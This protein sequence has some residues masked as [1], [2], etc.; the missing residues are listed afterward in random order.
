MLALAFSPA[1][2]QPREV[3]VGFYDN[4]PKVL[5]DADGRPAGIF[6]DLIERVAEAEDW[7]LA[8]E[9]CEWADCLERTVGGE[10]DLMPDVAISDARKE[11][12][13]FHAQPVLHSWS[14]VYRRPDVPISS[15]LDLKGRR[16]ALL[17]GSIQQA[18]LDA[19]LGDFG[20]SYE[21]VLV[22]D[23]RSAFAL[24]AQGE[25]DAAVVN[26]LFGARYHQEFDLT[27][28][29]MV[30]EPSRLFFATAKGENP[31]LLAVID[32]HLSAWQANGDSVFFDVLERWMGE[33]PRFHVPDW[34]WWM[35][36]M[37]LVLLLAALGVSTWLRRQVA[38]RTRRL[39]EASGALETAYQVIDASPVVLFRW[40]LAPGWPVEYVSGNVRRWGYEAE[41]F[42][43]GDL[44]FADVVHPDDLARVSADVERH[45]AGDTDAFRQEYRIV[46]PDGTPR[47]VEDLTRVTRDSQGRVER[48]EGVVTDVTERR[49]SE[50]RQR[51]AAAVIENTLEGVMITDRDERIIMVNRAFESLT[52]YSEAEAMGRPVTFLDAESGQNPWPRIR[53]QL[54]RENHWQGELTSRRKKG[55]VFPEL[56]T[57]SRVAGLTGEQD[58][59]VH[60][61]TDMSRLRASEER[62]DFLARHDSLTGLP[63]RTRLLSH[64]RER[65]AVS[66]GQRLGLLM[67]DLDRFRDI[68]ESYGHHVGDDLL[69]Q[70]AARLSDVPGN[71]F[72][73]RLGGDEFS[74]LREDFETEMDLARLAEGLIE[75]L[76]RPVA[77]AD[78]GEVRLGASIGITIYPEYGHTP[79]TLLQQA[80]AALYRAKTEGR[81][82]F[83]F[84]D[85]S[86]TSSARQ[87]T[88][89]ETRLRRAIE[90]EDLEMHYQPQVDIQTGQMIG[91]EAL[92]RWRD[93]S[94]GLIPPAVFIPI[95]EQSGLIRAL[96]EWVLRDVCRQ[97][98]EWL[99]AG[100]AVPRLA[101]NLSAQQ[102]QEADL[103]DR[104]RQI[105]VDTGYPADGLELELTESALMHRQEHA[106][107]V[108]HQLKDLGVQLAI[109]D[110]GTGYSSLAYLRQ[111]PVEV[112]KIDKR[113]I[114]D[115][116][117]NDDDREIATAI[118]AMGHALGLSVLA[119]GVETAEQLGFLRD[120]GCDS[121]QGYLFS[122]PLPAQDFRDLI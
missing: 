33:R 19:L 121:F 4:D 46:R 116:A 69:R 38:Q 44:C 120:N 88:E 77:L 20:L 13:D 59:V 98:R 51:E 97:G 82:S 29:P 65:M 8:F 30:F 14:Q 35:G 37:G 23:F 25:A 86:L 113:F 93:G 111:F 22:G 18:R 42:L 118:L 6:I 73:A 49:E 101:V 34:I 43:S 96:G 79:E 7:Q 68:N 3:T 91:A 70:V 26:H 31:E 27:R 110:F 47:W 90:Q 53:Q 119:E 54:E 28:T 15:I 78:V 66:N 16:V 83:R 39:V 12:L 24:V 17:E 71:R 117:E 114:D 64:M 107:S 52:D 109:D 105:L 41:A 61:F 40:R 55:E 85:E 60:M 10:I 84:F 50:R 115:L 106:M 102:L 87:R 32:R 48:L 36:A 100:L 99:D 89:L 95:A 63:N 108:L 94:R 81:G 104:V 112:L 76:S 9:Y 74:V 57:I 92:V 103:V 122:P 45:L 67:I 21:P 56:R 11:R 2:A 75:A 5:R 58:H 80:D 1:S 62:L 72:L